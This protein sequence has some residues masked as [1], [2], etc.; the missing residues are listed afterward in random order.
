MEDEDG[1]FPASCSRMIDEH[2]KE[3]YKTELCNSWANGSCNRAHKCPFAQ[4]AHLSQTQG[5]RLSSYVLARTEFHYLLIAK[6]EL[7]C[8]LRGKI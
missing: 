1:N 7:E 4:C 3:T 6:A 5:N 8:L 2:H